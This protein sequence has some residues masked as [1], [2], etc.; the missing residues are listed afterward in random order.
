MSYA[1]SSADFECP[2]VKANC[3]CLVNGQCSCGGKPGGCNCRCGC[4]YRNKDESCGYAWVWWLVLL[5]LLIW[6]ACAIMKSRKSSAAAAQSSIFGC[7]EN[8]NMDRIFGEAINQARR[9]LQ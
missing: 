8:E 4:R 3:P 5:A 9:R 1:N 7:G 6:A 2:C